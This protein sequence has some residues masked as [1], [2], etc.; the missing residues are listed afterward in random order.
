MGNRSQHSSARPRYTVTGKGETAPPFQG[1]TA[2]PAHAK[3]QLTRTEGHSGG[4]HGG[5][6]RGTRDG[7]TAGPSQ[8]KRWARVPPRR[9][10]R[11]R[12]R[13]NKRQ[14]RPERPPGHRDEAPP[15][16]ES[17]IGARTKPVQETAGGRKRVQPVRADAAQESAGVAAPSRCGYPAAKEKPS[18]KGAQVGGRRP[19]ERAGRM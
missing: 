15:A 16:T 7:R 6:S 3:A 5:R 10:G 11:P 14:R 12:T 17:A 4:P 2:R 18:A 13:P 19:P 1:N 8:R 9:A